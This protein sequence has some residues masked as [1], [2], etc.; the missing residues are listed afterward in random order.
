MSIG[1]YEGIISFYNITIPGFR[2]ALLVSGVC[3]QYAV[4][5]FIS[6]VSL[7]NIIMLKIYNHKN[8][9][10]SSYNYSNI[11]F[12]VFV[13]LSYVDWSMNRNTMDTMNW[14]T[15]RLVAD[16][17]L[18]RYCVAFN[19]SMD[20]NMMTKDCQNWLFVMYRSFMSHYTLRR[21]SVT[22]S[23]TSISSIL[24]RSYSHKGEQISDLS[25]IKN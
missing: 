22:M 2:L 9:Y 7:K 11:F 13:G 20:W 6:W 23:M 8:I 10:I 1:L 16:E 18:G 14:S 15:M 12:F 4:F 25:N 5:E 24:S 21:H 3:I 19:W 17:R